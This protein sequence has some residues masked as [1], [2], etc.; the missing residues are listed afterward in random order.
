MTRRT[1]LNLGLFA[2]GL[3]L[4]LWAWGCEPT[5][6]PSLTEV[7]TPA[8]APPSDRGSEDRLLPTEQQ[9]QICM[10]N[11]YRGEPPA[12]GDCRWIPNV[13]GITEDDPWG[14]FNCRTMDSCGESLYLTLLDRPG[15]FIEPAGPPDYYDIVYYSNIQ[16]R[17]APEY[18]G[19]PLGFEVPCPKGY[20][21][22]LKPQS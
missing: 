19:D 8:E 4:T 14:R 6:A 9:L 3:T 22:S 12:N 11:S 18:L 15:C 7:P 2:T 21:N 20:P 1:R 10:E 16:S 17:G 13:V 5:K